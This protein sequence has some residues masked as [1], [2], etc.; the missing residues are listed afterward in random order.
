MNFHLCE[1]QRQ[2]ASLRITNP[3]NTFLVCRISRWTESR[4]VNCS[5][6]FGNDC[7]TPF[8]ISDTI[9]SSR[10]GLISFGINVQLTSSRTNESTFGLVAGQS[11]QNA[12][13][14]CWSVSDEDEIL[15]GFHVQV[16]D[17]KGNDFSF[18]CRNDIKTFQTTRI[19][20]R[21]IGRG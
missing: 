14:G 13:I 3:H 19:V 18:A 21:I 12:V 20:S 7:I 2:S 11:G 4:W 16:F 9:A 17:F 8:V 1:L 15:F 6:T 10:I 5:I